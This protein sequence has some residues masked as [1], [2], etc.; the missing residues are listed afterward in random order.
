[1]KKSMVSLVLGLVLLAVSCQQGGFTGV[2]CESPRT[3]LEDNE[4]VVQGIRITLDTLASLGAFHKE[5]HRYGVEYFLLEYGFWC[6]RIYRADP[7]DRPDTVVF[8]W[9]I[10]TISDIGWRYGLPAADNTIELVYGN[11]MYSSEDFPNLLRTEVMGSFDD[12]LTQLDREPKPNGEFYWE[13]TIVRRLLADSSLSRRLENSRQYGPVLYGT[14]MSYN[15]NERFHEGSMPFREGPKGV[16][17]ILNSV[18]YLDELDSLA[19]LSDMPHPP[20]PQGI[21]DTVAI[22]QAFEGTRAGTI[23]LGPQGMLASKDQRI[24]ILTR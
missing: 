3:L 13:S 8:V 16:Y 19:R 17:R 2:P 20:V 6:N 11:G 9:F 12:F 24:G 18:D 5:H 7:E 23:I 14:D 22:R 15:T 21:D 1:M 4:Y 10:G